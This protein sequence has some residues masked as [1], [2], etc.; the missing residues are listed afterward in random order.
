MNTLVY[1]LRDFFELTFGF[2][3]TIGNA[4]NLMFIFLI[5]VFMV[6]WVIQMYKNPDKVK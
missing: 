2:M 6:Y 3:P 4:V 5:T 1:A